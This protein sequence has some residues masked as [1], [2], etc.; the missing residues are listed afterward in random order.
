MSALPDET[1]QEYAS[2]RVKEL[3]TVPIE[4]FG[5]PV[6][7]LDKDDAERFA[8]YAIA[9]LLQLGIIDSAEAARAAKNGDPLYQHA[10]GLL[11]LADRPKRLQTRRQRETNFFRDI[12]ITMLIDELVESFPPIRPTTSSKHGHSGSACGIVATAMGL[13]YDAV[14]KVWSRLGRQI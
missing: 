14:S 2:R 11:G 1:A 6:R 13:T 7:F 4:I 3:S 5:Q 9:H 12:A 8:G 10:L